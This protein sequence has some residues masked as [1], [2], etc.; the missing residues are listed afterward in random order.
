MCVEQKSMI[1]QGTSPRGIEPENRGRTRGLGRSRGRS[2]GRSTRPCSRGQIK[3]TPPSRACSGLHGGGRHG[4]WIDSCRSSRR[5]ESS[6]DRFADRA[7]LKT[8][9]ARWDDCYV[10]GRAVGMKA[11]L[12]ACDRAAGVSK[13]PT[14]VKQSGHEERVQVNQSRSFLVSCGPFLFWFPTTA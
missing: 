6:R 8:N 5:W 7:Q 1:E 13:G 3:A 2:A 12:L 10:A 11:S 4:W 14:A 9:R